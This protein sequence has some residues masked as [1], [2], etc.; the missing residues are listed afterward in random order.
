[1]RTCEGSVRELR[2][3][4]SERLVVI[5]CPAWAIPAPGE[6]LLAQ[7]SGSSAPLAAPLATPLFQGHLLEGAFVAA[8][9]APPEWEPGTRLSLRGPLGR[10]FKL[11]GRGL[12]L[13]LVCLG[14]SAGRLLALLA[15]ALAQ[16]CSVAVCADG[17]L[18]SLPLEVE[19]LPLEG[20]PELLGWAEFMALDLPRRRLGELEVL[21]A[22][23]PHLSGQVLVETPLACGGMAGCGACAVPGRRGARLACQDGPVFD[24]KDLLSHGQG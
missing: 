23:A 3:E 24:L 19:A 15:P 7:A 8:A 16:G 22:K 14:A 20:L 17:G 4:A 6:Y 2:L 18:P 21:L 11:P 9:P 13:G 5:E 10:G 1:M 12:R